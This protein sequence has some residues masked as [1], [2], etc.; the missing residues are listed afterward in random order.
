MR[1]Y[2]ARVTRDGK[3]W[4]IDIPEL[5]VVTQ[6]RTDDEIE[7]MARDVI[8]I[9]LDVEPDSFALEIKR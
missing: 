7:P 6:A 5:G 2:L 1:T 8:A 4:H 9:M 3:F